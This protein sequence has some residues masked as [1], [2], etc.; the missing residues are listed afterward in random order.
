MSFILPHTK[1]LHIRR[2]NADLQLLPTGGATLAIDIVADPHGEGHLVKYGFAICHDSD[3]YSRAVG[4]VKAQ[5]RLV[6]T[7]HVVK[8]DDLEDSDLIVIEQLDNGIIQYSIDGEDI[9]YDP[10]VTKGIQILYDHMTDLNIRK[11]GPFLAPMF[12][13]TFGNNEFGQTVM[14]VDPD[15]TVPTP[16]LLTMLTMVRNGSIEAV[17]EH[18]KLNA[19]HIECAFEPSL[20]EQLEELAKVNSMESYTNYVADFKQ[21]VD[22]E[23]SDLIQMMEADNLGNNTVH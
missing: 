11:F 17:V 9:D 4:R 13:V 22:E 21:M 16:V 7:K 12:N 3:Q 19:K 1:L 23:M 8:L 18:L 20:I 2:H 6:S 10:I 14:V 15:G 5:G